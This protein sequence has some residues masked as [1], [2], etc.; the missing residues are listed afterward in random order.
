MTS[1]GTASFFDRSGAPEGSLRDTVTE[2]IPISTGAGAR[3]RGVLAPLGPVVRTDD[4]VEYAVQLLDDGD[5]DYVAVV[6]ESG[7]PLGLITGG[8]IVRLQRENPQHW[9]GMRCGNV[10]VPPSRYLHPEDF[11]D[12]AVAVLRQDGVRPLLVLH[13]AELLGVL[14]PSAVFQWCAV[15]RPAALEELSQRACEW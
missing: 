1:A 11:F 6:D 15:H 14:E 2:S 10:I 13:G 3:I 12:V 9:A 5:V 7:G 8:D 4:G